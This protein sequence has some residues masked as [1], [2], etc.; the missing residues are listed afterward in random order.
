MKMHFFSALI[1]CIVSIASAQTIEWSFPAPSDNISGLAHGGNTIYAIDPIDGVIYMLNDWTGAVLDTI[2]LPFTYHTPVGLAYT[3][4]LETDTLWFSEAGTALIH[5]IDAS[6]SML[7][8]YDFSDSGVQSITGLDVQLIDNNPLTLMM[9]FIDS[10]TQIIY[11]IQLPISSCPLE[12]YIDIEGCPDVFDIGPPTSYYCIPVACSD[13]ISPVRCYYDSVSYIAM[14]GGTYE[15]AVGVAPAGTINRF[16]FSDPLMGMIHRYC[17]DMGGIEDDEGDILVFASISP[18]PTTGAATLRVTLT[19]DA[20]LDVC[21]YDMA[22]R[23]VQRMPEACYS[24][25]LNEQIIDGFGPG[26]FIVRV[27]APNRST[28]VRLVVLRE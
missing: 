15:S 11:R 6:G 17:M 3:G 22:G 2:P 7:A 8:T 18:N 24:A 10:A 21:V 1:G 13:P 28:T 23:L 12:E 9:F 16:Y 26:I 20:F 4:D 14:G 25:G 27:S 19:A 5:A